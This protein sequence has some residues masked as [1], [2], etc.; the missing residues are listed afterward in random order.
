MFYVFDDE[1]KSIE[2]E[3]IS[4]NMLCAG[5]MTV[6]EFERLATVFSLPKNIVELCKKDSDK[7]FLTKFLNDDLTFLRLN[8]MCNNNK[9]NEIALIIMKNMIM[10]V[11]IYD[12]FSFNQKCFL[13]ALSNCA[14]ES[15]TAEKLICSFLEIIA[16]QCSANYNEEEDISALE[17]AVI[18][19]NVSDNFGKLLIEK[20]RELLMLRAFYEEL[21]DVTEVFIENENEILDEK[22][23]KLFK[24]FRDKA[25]RYKENTDIQRDSVTHLWDAYQTSIDRGQNEIMKLFTVITSVFLPMT[26]IVGWYGMNFKYMPEI[27][28]RYGYVYV[29]LLNIAVVLTLIYI[30][31]KKKWI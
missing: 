19:K 21:I 24:L 16:K 10:A 30:F 27:S 29:I 20:K 18:D 7:N 3:E 13:N 25:V 6:G 31:K 1:L 28:F 9:N 23:L 8:I 4:K 2:I 22:S 15:V 26:V 17:K 11:D 14:C 12:E 5:F